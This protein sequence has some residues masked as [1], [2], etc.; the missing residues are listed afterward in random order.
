MLEIT[1][2]FYF[3]KYMTIL[4]GFL[5]FLAGIIFNKIWT[6]ILDFGILSNAVEKVTRDLLLCL[7]F[8]EEDIQYILESKRLMLKE[9]GMSESEIERFVL[10]QERSFRLWREK[11]IVTL[12]NSYP[13]TFRNKLPF[14]NWNGAAKYVNQI[15]VANRSK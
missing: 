4:S 12:L 8:V 14:D 5:L 13:D 11:I 7:V 1:W 6:F 2:P 15:L 10:M 9:K 3:G